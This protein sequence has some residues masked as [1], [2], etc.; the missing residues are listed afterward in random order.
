MAQDCARSCS[1]RTRSRRR[2]GS[3][4]LWPY[5]QASTAGVL[6]AAGGTAGY[7]IGEGRTSPWLEAIAGIRERPCPRLGSKP[8]PAPWTRSRVRDCLRR[9][10]SF[11]NFHRRDR[12]KHPLPSARW[13][14]RKVVALCMISYRPCGH[15][16][17][18]I[19]HRERHRSHEIAISYQRVLRMHTDHCGGTVSTFAPGMPGPPLLVADGRLLGLFA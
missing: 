15:R 8:V 5:K 4:R 17:C 19:I 7:A 12:L 13:C 3:P 2:G 16:S 11:L 10:F 9:V 18:N 6:A 14:R 1:G